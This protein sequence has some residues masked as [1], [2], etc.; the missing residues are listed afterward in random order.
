MHPA[1]PLL[2][3]ASPIP[4]YYQLFLRLRS[5]IQAGLARPGDLLGTEKAIQERF[6]VSRATVRKA[7]DE[8]AST[9]QLNRVTGRGT[10]VAEPTHE[11]HMPHLLSLTEE[12]H[13]RGIVPDAQVLA[14]GPVPA[15][16]AGATALGCRTGEPV[17]HIRRLRT[18]DGTPIV[19]V[20]H[21]LTPGLRLDRDALQQSLYATLEG[22][23][24]VRL[25]E[26]LH[27][28]SAGLADREEAAMLRIAP[29]DPVLRF[30]RTTLGTGGRP[31]LFEEGT[32]RGDLY[33]YSVHLRRRVRP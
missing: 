4:L 3:K 13:G 1:P 31:L 16:A 8:L 27:T 14:F 19:L 30:R 6:G 25:E 18:A 22:V 20:D 5:D 15:S 29:G 33:D 7:L 11:L 32:G 9:G 10:F 17:L 26:A 24:G 12:L 21:F 28:V 2:D 23:L